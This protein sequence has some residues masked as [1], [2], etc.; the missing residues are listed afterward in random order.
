[1]VDMGSAHRLTE[2]NTDQSLMNPV[3]KGSGGMEQTRKC[4]GRTD[5]WTEG[6]DRWTDAQTKAISIIPHPLHSG[7]LN[8]C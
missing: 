3:S 1:M 6:I 2:A 4:Y 8:I 7:G 5:G